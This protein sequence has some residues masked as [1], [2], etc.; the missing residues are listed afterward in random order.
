MI[1]QA[2]EQFLE[3]VE[4]CTCSESLGWLASS[5]EWAME[6]Y[7]RA[8]NPSAAVLK[9]MWDDEDWWDIEG[10]PEM[11]ARWTFWRSH[12]IEEHPQRCATC[13]NVLEGDDDTPDLCVCGEVR[14]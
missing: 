4:Q 7:P 9:V 6:K 11:E 13:G 12:E 3:L 10:I 1:E 14:A 2:R 5:I 8:K